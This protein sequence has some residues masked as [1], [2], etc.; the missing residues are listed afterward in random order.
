M[1]KSDF[2]Q[3]LAD[4]WPNSVDDS[5][6]RADWNWE[7]D[8]DLDSMTKDMLDNIKLKIETEIN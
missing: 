2:R 4:S 3:A 5:K 7:H 6:A 1:Y 8:F